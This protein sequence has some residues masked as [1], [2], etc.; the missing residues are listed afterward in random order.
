MAHDFFAAAGGAWKTISGWWVAVG[1]VWKRILSAHIAFGGTWKKFYQRPF[2]K[3]MLVLWMDTPPDGWLVCNGTDASPNLNGKFLKGASEEGEA[4]GSNTHTHS[5]EAVGS[6]NTDTT[7]CSSG[8]WTSRAARTWGHSHTITHAHS[9]VAKDWQPPYYE[10]IPAVGGP[11]LNADAVLMWDGDSGDIPDGWSYVSD[12]DTYYPKCNTSAAGG[13]GGNSTHSHTSA[14]AGADEG[15]KYTGY[16]ADNTTHVGSGI[17][18]TYC[19]TDAGSH[20]HTFAHSHTQANMNYNLKRVPLIPIAP[21]ADWTEE[22]PAG[23]IA[24][25]TGD[26]VPDGWTQLSSYDD[27]FPVFASAAGSPITPSKQTH[28]HSDGATTTSANTPGG[29][30]NARTTSNVFSRAGHTHTISNHVHSTAKCVPTKQ[31]P[32]HVPLMLCQ[33]D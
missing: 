22:I 5:D 4:G 25:F 27:F 32:A 13:T 31:E 14:F 33:K 7:A 6:T 19:M 2:P 8:T 24:F 21:D 28:E 26:T 17:V 3:N 23:V 9:A 1:G 12:L 15:V 10:L 18:D 16:V 20:R 29:S 30:S 11:L